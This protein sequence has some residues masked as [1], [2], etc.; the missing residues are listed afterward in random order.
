MSLLGCG[1]SI[2]RIVV[3]RL[4]E[5]GSKPLQ[6][7]TKEESPM[8]K[9]AALIYAAESGAP[10]PHTP[11]QQQYHG[12]YGAYTE[13][14][15]KAG[16]LTGGDGLLPTST[17]TTVRVRDGKTMTTDGPFAET[18]EQLG[19]FYMF[20]CK[21]LDEAIKWAAKIPDASRGSI[22]LRPVLEM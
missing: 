6:N 13:E 1:L 15:Q 8:P 18:R 21:D 2:C 4:F 5:S 22:E 10:A 7:Q 3:R 20:E 9:Y 14:V 16:I 12:A 17:A 11:E 19:G